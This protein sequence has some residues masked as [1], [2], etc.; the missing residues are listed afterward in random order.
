LVG[1][2]NER[3]E[4]AKQKQALGEKK[5]ELVDRKNAIE[6]HSIAR[7]KEQME[8]FERKWHRP[9]ASPQGNEE[10]FAPI[11]ARFVRLVIESKQRKPRTGNGSMLQEFET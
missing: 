1:P 11:D 4:Y 7:G 9:P 5:S 2:L 10:T 3:K 6:A 8:A